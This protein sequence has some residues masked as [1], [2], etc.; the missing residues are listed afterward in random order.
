MDTHLWLGSKV[1]WKI[2]PLEGKRK[3]RSACAHQVDLPGLVAQEWQKQQLLTLKGA[4]LERT[5]LQIFV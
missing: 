2:L 3:D 4:A 1:P 5:T